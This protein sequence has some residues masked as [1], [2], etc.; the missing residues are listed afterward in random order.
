MKYTFSDKEDDIYSDSNS[1]TNRRSSRNTRTHTPVEPAGPTI[2]QSGRQV[3]AR[4]GGTYGETILSGRQTPV[5]SG[6]DG[7]SDEHEGSS[8]GRPR[9]AAVAKTTAAA[10]AKGGK[11]IPGYNNVDEMTSDEEGDASEQDYGDDEEDDAISLASDIEEPEEDEDDDEDEE[12]DQ[13]MEIVKKSLIVKLPITSPTPEPSATT[14]NTTQGP[15][16]TN[17]SSSN[18]TSQLANAVEAPVMTPTSPLA[19]RG[20]PSKPSTLATPLPVGSQQP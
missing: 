5:P 17:P 16:S 14:S 12:G 19:F 4:Q 6:F 3:K 10:T 1:T 7:T 9:R 20:S 18:T 11:H 13:V 8:N 15:A 2:T